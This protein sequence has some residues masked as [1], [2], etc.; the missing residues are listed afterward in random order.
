MRFLVTNDD[1]I[2][3]PGLWALVKELIKLGEVIVVAPDREQSAIGTALTL[4]H[5][6]RVQKVKAEVSGWETW[7]VG[8]TPGDSVIMG[9]SI[10]VK[11]KID[12]VISGINNGPNIGDDVMISGTVGAAMQAFLHGVSAMAVSI[13][14]VDSLYIGDAAKIAVLLITN[15]DLSSAKANYFLNVNIPGLPLRKMTGVKITSLSTTGYC[16]TAEEGYDGRRHFYWLKH[17]KASGCAPRLSDAWAIAHH[18]VS[19][20]PL[21]KYFFGKTEPV[22]DGKITGLLDKQAP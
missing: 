12:L 4:H 1:G 3:A 17:Q 21:H 14:E 9:L 20:T 2:Y 7:A 10:F 16:D 15:L 18:N 22:F 6:L 8:G 13:D 19:I 5:P 11:D